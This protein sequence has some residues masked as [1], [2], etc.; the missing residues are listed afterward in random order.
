LINSATFTGNKTPI[1]GY[2]KTGAKVI[3]FFEL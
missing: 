3:L 1:S 2:T